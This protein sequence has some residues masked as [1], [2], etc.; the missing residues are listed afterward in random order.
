[1]QTNK[2]NL[3][4]AL[5][6]TLA[7]SAADVAGAQPY[8]GGFP[9]GGMMGPGGMMGQGGRGPGM[10]GGGMM[11][12][13]QRWHENRLAFLKSELKITP[14]QEK[15]WNAYAVAVRTSREDMVQRCNTMMGQRGAGPVPLPERLDLHEQFMSARLEQMRSLNKA[16]KVLYAVLDATQKKT[17]D[18][19]IWS[20]MGMM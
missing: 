6:S 18:E 9:C 4:F 5:A 1:M 12:V 19:L 17:A 11:G 2:R 8:D 15:E 3:V 14:A 16:L 7:L 20:P 13:G 10:M